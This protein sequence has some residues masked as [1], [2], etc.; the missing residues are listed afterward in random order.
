MILTIT[1]KE[2]IKSIKKV[3]PTAENFI[4]STV[5]FSNIIYIDFT[6]IDNS[7]L[8]NMRFYPKYKLDKYRFI[9]K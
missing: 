1:S 2:H 7:E 6:Y 5:D 9:K 8:I 3:Y 4:T